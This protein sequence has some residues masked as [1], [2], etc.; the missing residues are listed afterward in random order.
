M[1]LLAAL[2]RHYRTILLRFAAG[3]VL[4]LGL[5]TGL[6]AWGLGRVNNGTVERVMRSVRVMLRLNELRAAFGKQHEAITYGLSRSV[7]DAKAA[8]ETAQE[9]TQAALSGLRKDLARHDDLLLLDRMTYAQ[10]MFSEQVVRLFDY[11]AKRRSLSLT[12]DELTDLKSYPLQSLKDANDHA[13]TFHTALRSLEE[14]ASRDLET[15]LRRL[16][17]VFRNGLIVLLAVLGLAFVILLG[18]LG[19]Y[20][21]EAAKPFRKLSEA[22]RTLSD[23]DFRTIPDYAGVDDEHLRFVLR[24]IS[25]AVSH[26]RNFLNTT[27]A[28]LDRVAK[29][30]QPLP[31]QLRDLRRRLADLRRRTEDP[32][33]PPAPTPDTHPL[34]ETLQAIQASL[35]DLDIAALN[36]HLT[37]EQQGLP[38]LVGQTE[39]IRSAISPIAERHRNALEA[40]RRLLQRHPS[41]ASAPRRHA[42]LAE[43]LAEAEK[44]AQ[45]LT[46]AAADAH[47]ALHRLRNEVRHY[48]SFRPRTAGDRE[49]AALLQE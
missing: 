31:N 38:D 17:G 3:L 44:T 33:A 48:E 27:A 2:P 8:Y 25:T 35:D 41:T 26:F 6:V 15:E 32:E 29:E 30:L 34:L 37:A 19:L 21:A 40:L 10:T 39:K 43:A 14:T 9:R 20:A 16:V 11:L 22:L 46:T 7:A 42:D 23:S 18:G 36:L 28:S 4:F 47:S 5:L 1:P 24:N 12:Y 49:T 13:E 45:T